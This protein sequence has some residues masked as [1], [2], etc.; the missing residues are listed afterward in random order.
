MNASGS[1]PALIG[2]GRFGTALARRLGSGIWLAD[3]DLNQARRIGRLTGA[4]VDTVEALLHCSEVLLVTVPPQAVID[5]ALS[6]RTR[7]KEGAIWVNFATSVDN[8]TIANALARPDVRVV[9]C[10]PVAQATALALGLPAIF[11]SASPEDECRRRLAQIIA[12]AGVLVMGDEHKVCYMNAE[13]TRI[14]LRLAR[15]LHHRLA[16]L[17]APLIDAAL[18][19]VVVG[20]LMDFPEDI[21]NPYIQARLVEIE[22]A[23]EESP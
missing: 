19:N 8:A 6:H 11:V 17:P 16:G 23:Q 4:A 21:D 13:A 15:N 5:L 9:G 18:K 14:A 10:K 20:T 7:L 1:A 2:I 12:P 3:C 22:Q